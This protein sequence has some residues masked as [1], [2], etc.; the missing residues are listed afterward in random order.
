MSF[1]PRKTGPDS[2]GDG[3][4]RYLDR[5]RG[6]EWRAPIF[7]D[8]IRDDARRLGRGLTWLD[9]GCGKG[10]DDDLALQKS[11]AA[12]AGR[13]IGIEPDRAILIG[14]HV[15]DVHR[16][17]FEEAPLAA[18]SVDV[19][20]SSF[21]LEHVPEPGRFFEKLHEVLVEGG[22]FWG[23]TVDS[24]HY[25]C[26][27]SRLIERLRLKDWYL[28]CLR[29]SWGEGYGNY[30]TYYR[31][32]SPGRIRKQTGRFRRV[33]FIRFHRVGQLEPGAP[34]RSLRHRHRAARLGAHREVGE[35]T[36]VSR[37]TD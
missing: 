8:M 11:L 21:V 26:L 31:A 4:S 36:D 6:G 20:F 30:P 27:L 14:P 2:P 5:Y 24:R 34:A 1:P 29:R 7:R 23:L 13:Y 25:F 9:I 28:R 35:V 12:E 19:A 3:W 33:D 16:C 17:V 32:N 10:L 37:R 22:V 18:G 15:T